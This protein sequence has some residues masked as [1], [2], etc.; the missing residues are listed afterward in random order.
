MTGMKDTSDVYQ[1]HW[2]GRT[3]MSTSHYGTMVGSLVL[4]REVMLGVL[5]LQR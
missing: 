4:G 3:I 1:G 5:P 2:K